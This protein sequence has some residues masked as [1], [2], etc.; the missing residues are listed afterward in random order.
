MNPLIGSKTKRLLPLLIA[1][2]AV[3]MVLT[4]ANVARATQR[5]VIPVDHNAASGG[6]DSTRFPFNNIAEALTVAGSLGDAVVI[7]APGTYP[8]SSTLRIQSSIDLRGSNVME[9][10]DAGWP[11]ASI[12]PGTETRIVGTEALGTSDLVSAGPSDNG[13]LHGVEIRN[14]TFDSGPAR[15]ND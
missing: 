1:L 15:G 4:G 12:A 10:D 2:L 8:V 13:I 6:D 14:L 11:T 9:V 5:G 3:I 7:V